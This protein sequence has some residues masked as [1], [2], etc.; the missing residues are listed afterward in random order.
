MLINHKPI[1]S[2]NIVSMGY[3]PTLQVLEVK[4]CNGRLYRYF[5]VPV[6]TY[7][8]M[9]AEGVEGRSVGKFFISNVRNKFIC[10]RV[11]CDDR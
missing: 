11:V 10:E 9:I 5:K 4:F 7:N 8:C 3:E 6:D 1:V 2:S